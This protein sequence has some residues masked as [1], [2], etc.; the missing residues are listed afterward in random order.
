[1][2]GDVFDRPLGT[3]CWSI[4]IV[5]IEAAK[6]GQQLGVEFLEKLGGD[7]DGLGRLHIES[8]DLWGGGGKWWLAVWELFDRD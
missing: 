5:V 7:Q 8:L 2:G 1:M 4:P 6:E 3:N